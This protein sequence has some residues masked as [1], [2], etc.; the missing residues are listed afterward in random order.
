M[1]LLRNPFPLL[2]PR[3]FYQLAGSPYKRCDDAKKL[4]V[5]KIEWKKCRPNNFN[6]TSLKPN[7]HTEIA[8]QQQRK[9][10]TFQ[11]EVFAFCRHRIKKKA[12]THLLLL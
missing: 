1:T 12:F 10:P 5:V 8:V 2:Q 7:A 11:T 3:N 4:K 6:L 9:R